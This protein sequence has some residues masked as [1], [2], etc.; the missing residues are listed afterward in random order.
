MSRMRTR[1]RCRRAQQNEI[2]AEF[3]AKRSNPEEFA[4]L[5]RRIA[6]SDL[7]LWGVARSAA[8]DHP[9]DDA[10]K[11]MI[12]QIVAPQLAGMTHVST[13]RRRELGE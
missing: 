8:S 9:L 13:H 5:L 4:H 10:E 1:A 3:E 2:R 11:A 7:C 6:E 12:A